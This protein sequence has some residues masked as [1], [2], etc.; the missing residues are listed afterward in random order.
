MQTIA[1]WCGL[2][3]SVVDTAMTNGA[4]LGDPCPRSVCLPAAEIRIVDLE[5]T[6]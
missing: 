2:R 1:I 5:P 4:L 6:G 3:S